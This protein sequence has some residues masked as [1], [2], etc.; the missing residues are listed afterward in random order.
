MEK[1][2]RSLKKNFDPTEYR[3]ITCPGC[4]EWYGEDHQWDDGYCED[5]TS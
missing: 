4:G 5:C 3:W 2:G 1:K